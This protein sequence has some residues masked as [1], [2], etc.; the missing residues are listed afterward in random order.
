MRIYAA[1]IGCCLIWG[2]T[3]LAIR[4]GNEAIAPVWGAALRLILAAILLLGISRALRMPLP[5]GAALRGAALYGFFNFGVN[6]SLLYLG[7]QTVP[8]GIAA[9]LFATVP[10][11]TALLAAGLGVERLVIRKL[12]AALV[13]IVGVAVIFAGELGAAVPLAGLLTVFSGA[14]AAALSGVLLKQ[15]PKQ[16]AIPANAVG[17]GV[18]AIVCL[19]VSFALG[20]AHTLPVTVGGWLPLLYLVV[21][22]SL[23]A[24][25][26]FS[27]LIARWSVTNASLIGVI[28]PIIAVILGAIVKAEAPAPLT[29]L[30]AAIVIAA[31]LVAIRAPRRAAEPAPARAA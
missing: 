29:Y 25:V 5:R 16:A 27:W 20:E 4:L 10:L 6:F 8:S 22:G 15:A 14:T 2:S 18:G 19:L 12:V 9:V 26:L 13:A 3:F 7:E 30:G 28:V 24:F 23:G 21:A 11:S 1:F 31:V 17:A